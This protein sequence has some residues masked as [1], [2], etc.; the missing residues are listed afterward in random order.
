MEQ[1]ANAAAGILDTATSTVKN[2]VDVILAKLNITERGKI[3]NFFMKQR[4]E[5][6]KEIRDLT[7]NKKTLIDDHQDAV[8]DLNEKL[9]DAQVEVEEAYSAVTV[10]DISSNEKAK[11]FANNY[12]DNIEVAEQRVE[13]IKDQ[14]Q[15][16]EEDFKD[17]IE[18]IDA[19]IDERQRRLNK[20]S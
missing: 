18:E 1:N 5:L 8:E 9:A 6:N 14:I 10:E 20:I 4:S 3:E 11:A 7:K 16:A 13:G 17:E 2:I 15:D 19:Q 12:W